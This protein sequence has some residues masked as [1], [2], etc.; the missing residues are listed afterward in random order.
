MVRWVLVV[1]VMTLQIGT[2]SVLG[3]GAGM[4]Q[5]TP[6]QTGAKLSDADLQEILA[7]VALY[8]DKL[9]ASV[10]AASVFPEVLADAQ[11]LV[12]SGQKVTAEAHPDW[13]TS[14]VTVAQFPEALSLLAGNLEWTRAM[15]EAF[16]AQPSDVMSAVQALRA[17]AWQKGSL[18]TNANQTV[19]VEGK[20]II[21]EPAQPEVV[22]VPTYNPT[23]VYVD[24]HDDDA[25]AAALVGFGLGVAV[26]LIASD[27]DCDWH[28]GFVCWGWGWG[29]FHAHG[30]IDIDVDNSRNININN[31][32]VAP[33]GREGTRWGAD[34]ALP[35]Q[36]KAGTTSTMARYQGAG[37]GRSPATVPGR[38]QGAQPIARTPAPTT[39]QPARTRTERPAAP[40]PR[41]N[42]GTPDSAPNRPS[43]RDRSPSNATP[44]PKPPTPSTKPAARPSQSRPSG[45]SPSSTGSRPRSGGGG[46][47]GRR[48]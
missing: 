24:D 13:D 18:R 46:G 29:G 37:T 9:L 2:P 4:A 17:R 6:T 33:Y 41:Q 40:T 42:T 12:K 27:L 28:G 32:R 30:S 10:L 3:V 35:R 43:T 8:P 1:G 19:V 45:F 21:I 26:G 7:P 5:P 47:G 38:A 20:V 31:P 22:Y 48:R 25:A 39:L 15:G 44:A 11:R 16:L 36:T 23:V 14:V 34:P